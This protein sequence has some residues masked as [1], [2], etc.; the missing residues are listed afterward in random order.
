MSGLVYRTNDVLLLERVRR[1]RHSVW[2]YRSYQITQ[3][4]AFFCQDRQIR[5]E[6]QE[7]TRIAAKHLVSL[8]RARITSSCLKAFRRLQYLQETPLEDKIL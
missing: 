7:P 5:M 4:K 8:A 6:S 1:R 2:L 3:K